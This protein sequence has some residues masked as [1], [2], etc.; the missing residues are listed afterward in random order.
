MSLELTE[1]NE[2]RLQV[3]P[4]EDPSELADGL[5]IGRFNDLYYVDLQPWTD[6]PSGVHDYRASSCYAAGMSL[7]S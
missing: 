7:G 2:L 1:V 3:R 5:T 6:K 4:T